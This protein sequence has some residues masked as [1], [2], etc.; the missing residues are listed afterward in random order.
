MQQH[1]AKSTI[2]K[3]VV[4]SDLH[5]GL[6]YFRCVQFTEFLSSLE[7]GFD[8]ILN[9]DVIDDPKQKLRRSGVAILDLLRSESYLRRVF[10]T[11]G[12]HDDG[13]ELGDPG[14]IHFC[15]YLEVNGHLLVVHG[16]DFDEIMPKSLWFIRVMKMLHN[17]RIRLGARPVHIAE[18][19]KKRLPFLYR[20]LTE[21]VK[22][23]AVTCALRNGFSAITCGHTHYVEDAFCEGVRYIN[24]GAWTEEPLNCLRVTKNQLSLIQI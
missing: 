19:A 23:N 16:D 24:T 21:E 18:F 4:V 1:F 2:E 9:G 5:V 8:L 14:E 7:P 17:Q 11:Y 6:P 10:W 22:K 20:I 3:A 13:L 15:K 12:N